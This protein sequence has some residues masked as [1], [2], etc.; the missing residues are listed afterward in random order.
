MGPNVRSTVP[1]QGISLLGTEVDALSIDDLHAVISDAINTNRRCIIG[2][3]NLHSIFTARRSLAMQAFYDLA[4]YRRIDGMPI[5]LWGRL[6]GYPLGPEHRVTWVDWLRPF[7][8]EAS[9]RQ[10][11]IFYLGSSRSVI[12]QGAAWARKTFPDLQVEFAHGY[13]DP[14]PGAAE[15]DAIVE[16]V[17]SFGAD[18]LLVGMG[19][20]RQERWVVDNAEVLTVPVILPCGACLDYVAGAIPTPPRWMGRLGV[21][22]LYR[23]GSEPKRLGSRYLIEPWYL[24]PLFLRD[25]RLKLFPE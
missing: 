6:L 5:V 22:W 8:A 15:N 11:R 9:E 13:F 2:S 19:M 4:A 7:L 20:P 25:V 18:V 12:E 21:E 24:L 3:Q 10:W 14:R 23:L 1:N 17:N 16:Q